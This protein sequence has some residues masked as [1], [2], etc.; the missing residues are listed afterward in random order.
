MEKQNY[1]VN[2]L[3]NV[4]VL[5]TGGAGFIGSH[6]ADAFINAGAIVHV[7]DNL[8]TGSIDNIQHLLINTRFHFVRADI[9]DKIVLDRIAS[10][11]NV[12]IHLAAAVGVQLIMD[13]PVQ[14]IETNVIGTEM[15]LK[16]ALRY[17]C[18]VLIASTSEVYGKGIKIP[19]I[20]TN[21]VLLGTTDKSRWAYACSKMM[22]EFLGYAYYSEYCLPVVL[23]RLFNTIGP[24][25]TG[26]YGMVVPRFIYSA[27]HNKPINVYGD[28]TQSRCFCNVTD[29]TRALIGL[30]VHTD[31]PGQLFNIGST[32]EISINK[33]AEK[34]ITITESKSVIV[35][36][37]YNEAYSSGFE[38]MQRRVPDT[39]KIQSLLKWQ[40]QIGLDATVIE[41]KNW[42]IKNLE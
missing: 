39:T 32:D 15:V 16:A 37:P 14:T 5:I 1:E 11:A 21:D 33:L 40:P 13:Y 4:N 31:A 9:T 3:S 6:L 10:Q 26:T 12:I 36:I 42:M 8:S 41:I 24:R 27:L 19:F 23:M 2:N 18:R 34:V 28:G 7:I 35:N 20:E 29:V 17:G 30:A 22:D 25:Q 38:D